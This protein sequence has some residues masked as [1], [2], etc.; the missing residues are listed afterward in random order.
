MMLLGMVFANMNVSGATPIEALWRLVCR[1]AARLP[2]CPVSG[3]RLRIAFVYTAVSSAADAEPFR[4]SDAVLSRFTNLDYDVLIVAQKGKLGYNNPL[5][6]LILNLHC[7]SR[8]LE[9]RNVQIQGVMRA[10]RILRL[11]DAWL[12]AVARRH[13]FWEA[14]VEYVTPLLE[15]NEHQAAT[16]IELD[17]HYETN[18]A[19]IRQ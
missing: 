3:R 7:H 14:V 11:D 2:A 10:I 19:N 9:S 12:R 6:K 8:T 13:G 5:V 17:A 1:V 4:D 18:Q 15:R 16:L